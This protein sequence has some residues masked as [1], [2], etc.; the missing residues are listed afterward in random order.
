MRPS[1]PVRR[2]PGIW[3]DQRQRFR[4]AQT[5]K[6]TKPASLADNLLRV[7]SGSALGLCSTTL[8]TRGRSRVF[9][10]TGWGEDLEH[11]ELPL[12]RIA[13]EY[14]PPAPTADTTEFPLAEH[15]CETDNQD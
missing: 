11:V 10:T 4:L 8:G 14:P 13:S 3:K 9:G 12:I 1:F 15:V 7:C 2:N 5:F 6:P